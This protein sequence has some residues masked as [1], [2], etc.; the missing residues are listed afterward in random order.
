MNYFKLSQLKSEIKTISISRLFLLFFC[1]CLGSKQ[2]K[3][4]CSDLGAAKE[5]VVFTFGDFISDQDQIWGRAAVGGKFKVSSWGIGSQGCLNDDPNRFDLVVGGDLDYSG[6]QVNNGSV[7]YGGSLI[8]SPTL[9][10]GGATIAQAT[11]INFAAAETDLKAKSTFWATLATTGTVNSNG[12][13]QIDLTGTSSGLNVFN[14]TAAEIQQSLP[15]TFLNVN[16]DVPAGSTVLINVSGSLTSMPQTTVSYNG[17]QISTGTTT[18]NFQSAPQSTILWNLPSSTT[19]FTMNG[20]GFQGSILAPWADISSG[21]GEMN[22]TLIAKSI[23]KNGFNSS[24]NIIQI[25]C[26]RFQGCLPPNNTTPVCSLNAEV[27]AVVCKNLSTSNSSDDKYDFTLTLTATGDIGGFASISGGLGSLT[28]S[29]PKSFVN[30][31]NITAGTQTFTITAG[32]NCSSTIVTVNPPASCSVA[33][34]YDPSILNPSYASYTIT[35]DNKNTTD[36][37]DDTISGTFTL[38]NIP[39]GEAWSLSRKLDA[40]GNAADH[41]GD[42]PSTTSTVNWGPVPVTAAYPG[43]N[44]FVLWFML[45]SVTDCLGDVFVTIPP[46][47]QIQCTNPTA[48]TPAVAA[49]TCNTAGTAANADASISITGITNG[50][51]YAFTTDGST[52]TFASATAISGSGI[53]LTGITNPSTAV[54][55]QFRIFNGS[56]DCFTELTATLNPKTCTPTLK[57]SLGDFVW[58]DTNNNGIQDETTANGGGVVGVQIELYKNSVAT[59][60]IKT[61]D[62]TGKYLF[63]NLEAATYKIKVLSSSIPTG[64][65]ISSKKDQLTNDAIDSDVDPN[66]VFSGDYIID[67]T[68]S[69]KKDIITVD[70]GLY[71]PPIIHDLA[72]L[73]SI[74]KNFVRIGNTVT[75]TILLI[76]QGKTD[77]TGVEVLDTLSSSFMYVSHTAP[78]GTI[79]NPATGKWNVGSIASTTDT[80]KLTITAKV[81]LEGVQFNK[82]EVSKM[83]GTDKDSTPNNNVTT[84]DDQASVCVSVPIEFCDGKSIS[85]LL[86]APTGYP[87]YTWYKNGVVIANATGNTYTAIEEGDYT[88]VVTGGTVGTCQGTNCC[89]IRVTKISCP[90]GAPACIPVVIKRTKRA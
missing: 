25:H 2:V 67:P 32:N 27:S 82:A 60:I 71:S 52:P 45:N 1:L 51:V 6:G 30:Q 61:T 68:D 34:P 70:I 69:A 23:V 86:T 28:P 53:S 83:D 13:G 75:F 65:V 54:T 20:V 3:A 5:Y 4:Q 41:I 44:G 49:A 21:G 57:G 81:L 14:V 66:T 80:L 17:S 12:F 22:G 73:K 63:D 31:F 9:A 11:P 29:V 24:Q 64:C 62:A 40:T 90:C 46:A 59:G 7:R 74:D 50:T 88:F 43:Q 55:Y 8:S 47:P 33:C 42:Y 87:S 77:V 78:T 36:P 56:A 79:Y 58:K 48:G 35:R 18:G 76:N 10:L 38:N 72:L 85:L 26:T 37:T 84:E 15:N 16:I 19:A 89:P 39:T